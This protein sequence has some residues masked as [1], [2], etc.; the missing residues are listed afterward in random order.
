[1]RWFRCVTAALF[2]LLGVVALIGC[3]DNAPPNQ[4]PNISKKE[5]KDGQKEDSDKDGSGKGDSD[6]D[7]SKT[8]FP[9]KDRDFEDKKGMPG[10]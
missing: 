7:S 10:K 3:G 5:E 6:K 8:A 9:G 4:R 2:F 1:M